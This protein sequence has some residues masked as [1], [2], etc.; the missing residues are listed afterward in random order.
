MKIT[1]FEELECW[2]EARVL[3]GLVYKIIRTDEKFFKDYKL[4]DQVT[5]AAVSVMSNIAEGFS[6]QTNKEFIQFL[7]ISKSSASEVQSIFYLALDLGYIDSE[8]FNKVYLQT[9]KVSQITSGLIRYLLS[10][11]KNAITQ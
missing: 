7:Y 11:R 6:R 9:D 2:K 10:L 1:R 8:V 4:R 3:V 5:S